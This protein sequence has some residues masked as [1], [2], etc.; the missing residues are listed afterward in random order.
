MVPAAFC[1][2]YG[3]MV[4]DRRQGRAL[5][6]A[7]ALLPLLPPAAALWLIAA[8]AIGFDLGIQVALIAHQSIVYGIDPAARSRLNAVLMVSVFIGMATG[9]ALGSLALAHWG[10]IGVTLVATAAAGGALLLRLWPAAGE[11]RARA[12]CAA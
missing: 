2:T 8:S 10:W 1:F 4:G 6:A 3:R 5:F 12:G 9:G 11:R 7:M